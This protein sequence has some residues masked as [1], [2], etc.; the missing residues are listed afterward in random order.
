[1]PRVFVHALAAVAI[2]SGLSLVFL[3]F[4][5]HELRSDLTTTQSDL[6]DTRDVL[7]KTQGDLTKT[8]HELQ[9][10]LTESSV[11]HRKLEQRS[12]NSKAHR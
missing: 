5:L 11:S 1:M 7:T 4:E 12:D 9:S 8:L 2:L 3:A 6:T 10:D